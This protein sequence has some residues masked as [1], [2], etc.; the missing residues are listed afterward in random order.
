M[1]LHPPLPWDGLSIVLVYPTTAPPP[2]P[3]DGLD[4]LL[5]NPTTAPPPA[6]GWLVYIIS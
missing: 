4:I 6:V 2:L 5:V 3:W 1:M